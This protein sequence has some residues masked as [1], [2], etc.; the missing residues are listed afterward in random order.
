M[1]KVRRTGLFDALETTRGVNDY[2][3]LKDRQTAL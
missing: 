3:Q 2:H 1:P